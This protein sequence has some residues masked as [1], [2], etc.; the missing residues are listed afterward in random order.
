M[1]CCSIYLRI[2]H[3]L[4]SRPRWPCALRHGSAENA[5]ARLVY[6]RH[7]NLPTTCGKPLSSS[8]LSLCVSHLH[9]PWLNRLCSCLARQNDCGELIINSVK[10]MKCHSSLAD[11]VPNPT[12]ENRARVIVQGQQAPSIQPRLNKIRTFKTASLSPRSHRRA[13]AP[14]LPH[15]KH[16]HR[17]KSCQRF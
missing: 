1:C 5:A 9:K 4:E 17:R 2:T 8:S 14:I 11:Y 3:V 6:G 10:N 16:P 15:L 13:S 12:C 7:S